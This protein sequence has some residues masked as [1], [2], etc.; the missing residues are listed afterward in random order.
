MKSKNRENYVILQEKLRELEE[1]LFNTKE[2]LK[3]YGYKDSS[4]NG[5]LTALNEKAKI[6][7]FQINLLKTKMER[8]NQEDDKTITY[9]ILATG[10]KKTVQLTNGETDPD[11]GKISRTSPVGMALDKKKNGEVVEVKISQKRYQ[12]QIID[13]KEV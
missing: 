2:K 11:Q 6:Y 10:E 3:M 8:V 7:Q 5:D 9:K 13:I 12:I 4:E 1:K